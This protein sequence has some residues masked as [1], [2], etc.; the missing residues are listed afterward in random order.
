MQDG[1]SVRLEAALARRRNTMGLVAR[2]SGIYLYRSTR[3]GGRAKTVYLG[4]GLVA[5]LQAAD[6]EERRAQAQA[7]REEQLAM[8]REHGEIDRALAELAREA[9]DHARAAL[10][11]AGFHQ[12]ARGRWRR[13]R[14]RA[15]D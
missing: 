2:G 3:K 1:L 6:I 12:H 11:S 9:M 7:R 8:E 5:L 14:A 4:S 13:R 15:H 10:E